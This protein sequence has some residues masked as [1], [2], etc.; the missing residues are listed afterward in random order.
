MKNN[1]ILQALGLNISSNNNQYNNPYG[2]NID[3][4]EGVP[5]EE[6]D[7][8]YNEN[9]ELNEEIE[10][11]EQP[12]EKPPYSINDLLNQKSSK[13]QSSPQN[14]EYSFEG[15]MEKALSRI[16]DIRSQLKTNTNDMNPRLSDEQ[17]GIAL[18]RGMGA[19]Y[20]ADAAKPWRSSG[21][22]GF[23]NDLG[24]MMMQGLGGYDTSRQQMLK[25][26][27]EKA[28]YK[29]A[30]EM[31]QE[32]IARAI[33][34]DLYSR[35]YNQQKLGLEREKIGASNNN[36]LARMRAEAMMQSSDTRKKTLDLKI[37]ENERKNPDFSKSENNPYGYDIESASG[38]LAKINGQVVSRASPHRIEKIDN[39]KSDISF[40]LEKMNDLEEKYLSWKEKYN[41]T[42]ENNP[43]LNNLTKLSSIRAIQNFIANLPSGNKTERQK[44][45]EYAAI[46]AEAGQQAKA[47]EKAI[48]GGILTESMDKHFREKGYLPDFDNDNEETF[49][50]KFNTTRHNI[51]KLYQALD[52]SSLYRLNVDATKLIKILDYQEKKFK[53]T[54]EE[55]KSTEG[56]NAKVNEE[57]S[58]EE[59]MKMFGAKE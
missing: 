52:T 1:D 9:P 32:A 27:E 35:D 46:A 41:I 18:R 37:E 30:L 25:E 22:S 29:Q 57:L 55:N 48:K 8:P 50:T 53:K 39:K 45:A 31:Q 3:M 43:T 19:A 33:E 21:T 59:M 36:E 44:W 11:Y 42:E 54:T 5:S 28:K 26:N 16:N 34:H 23:I 58:T 2:L 7:N 20:Q 51:E 4:E 38:N 40:E 56:N 49:W 6:G 14:K 24:G 12:S 15:G 13:N 47:T 10:E 17:S